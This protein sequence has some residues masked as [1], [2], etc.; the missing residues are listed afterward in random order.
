MRF[1]NPLKKLFEPKQSSTILTPEGWG[2]FPSNKPVPKSIGN[3]LNSNTGWA[4]ACVDV[5]A[6]RVASINY[7]LFKR[8]VRNGKEELTPITDHIFYDLLNQPNPYF[9]R[10]HLMYLLAAHMKLAGVGY[11]Y[12]YVNRTGRPESIWPLQPDK[13]EKKFKDGV[14]SYKYQR[15]TK[16][17]LELDPQRVLEFPA[18]NVK[19]IYSGWSPLQAAGI[20]YDISEL[21]DLYQHNLFKGGGW[22]MYA[23]STKQS[24]QSH[25][26][27]KMRDSWMTL[28][29]RTGDRFKPPILHSGTEIIPGPSNLDLDLTSLDNQQRDKVLGVYRVPKSKLGFS[30]SANK[31]SMFAADVAFNQEVI[32]PLLVMIDSVFDLRL[33][34]L[35]G[36]KR[37][38]TGDFENPVPTDREESRADIEQQL[39]HGVIT[40]NEA[41]VM[42][43]LEPIK[44]P[45]M[46]QPMIP[47]NL[48]PVGGEKSAVPRSKTGTR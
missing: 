38:L 27:D 21:I 23:L 14:V 6:S 17:P 46:D 28:F 18:P 3:A 47:F 7:K 34:P 32:Q 19:H 45:A 29:K 16:G 24:L 35:Y 10:W 22:F 26:M 31:A 13:V 37:K 15:D 9:S 4:F 11:W 42:A 33:L 30:E 43:G 20:N 25:E 2:Q 12:L 39:K 36:N 8:G 41:R 44:V 48:V 40:R 1:L 5:I